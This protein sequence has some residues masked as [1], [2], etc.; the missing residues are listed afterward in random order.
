MVEGYFQSTENL[1]HRSSLD[2]LMYIMDRYYYDLVFLISY[3]SVF[4]ALVNFP[5]YQIVEELVKG[6][7]GDTFYMN[8]VTEMMRAVVDAGCLTQENVLEYLGKSFRIKLNLPEWYSDEQAA[9]FIL[10]YVCIRVGVCD[11]V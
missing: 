7:E 4:Q 1:N 6:K 3:T 5:D 9:D 2:I 11:S 10:K 8:C